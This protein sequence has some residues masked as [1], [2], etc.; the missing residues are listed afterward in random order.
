MTRA[1]R[2]KHRFI[3]S[4]FNPFVV[5]YLRLFHPQ[6]YVGYLV[7]DVRLAMLTHWI[8]PD[9]LHPEAGLADEAMFGEC[10]KHGLGV[11]LWTVNSL[12]GI[13]WCIKRGVSGVITDNPAS[14]VL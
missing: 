2:I 7:D 4:C 1:G 8:H 10:L 12:P 13:Q 5:G 6:V 14:A 3:L 11:N 9:F